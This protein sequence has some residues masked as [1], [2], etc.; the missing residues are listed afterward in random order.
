MNC[1]S[2]V[3]G[4]YTCVCVCVCVYMHV[5][6]YVHVC[7]CTHKYRGAKSDSLPNLSESL[8]RN[9][10]KMYVT[11]YWRKAY[12]FSIDFDNISPTR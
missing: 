10:K 11:L 1:T 12:D 7:M 9:T 5:C 2:S 4:D 6:M 8:P 3:E